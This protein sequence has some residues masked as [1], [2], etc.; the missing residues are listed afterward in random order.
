MDHDKELLPGG[1]LALFSEEEIE[2]LLVSREVAVRKHTGAGLRATDPARYMEV[3]AAL[4]DGSETYRQIAARLHVSRNLIRAVAEQAEN[5]DPLKKR[6]ARRARGLASLCI[7]RL[8][9]IVLDDSSK[10]PARDLAIVAGVAID[11]SQVLTGEPTNITESLRAVPSASQFEGQWD[12]LRQAEGV[13]IEPPAGDQGAGLAG[14]GPQLLGAGGLADPAAG[15]LAG[16]GPQL[17]DADPGAG[18]LAADP[19]AGGLAGH[20][21]Q[22]V[23]AD[24]GAGGL[25]GDPGAGGLAGHGPQLVDADPGAGGLAGDPGA[26]RGPRLLGADPGAGGLADPAGHRTDRAAGC[27]PL[28]RPALGPRT[29]FPD[30]AGHASKT[31]PD[32]PDRALCVGLVLFW[33]CLNVQ[34]APAVRSL[35]SDPGAGG[36]A[37]VR[38][39]ASD[40][41]AGGLAMVR[42]CSVPIRPAA[43]SGSASPARCAYSG[44]APGGGGGSARNAVGPTKWVVPENFISQ[45][46]PSVRPHGSVTRIKAGDWVAAWFK[47]NTDRIRRP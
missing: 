5:V 34:K 16:H 24:P 21:P 17:V 18:G 26:G 46:G 40:P 27:L 37:M 45:R 2:K 28:K 7:E 22:L 23:D 41:G 1:Q 6:I 36:L 42:S 32:V 19:G 33:C 35:A 38:S 30:P 4:A 3:C 29:A 11:K 13:V 39:L 10:I 43:G 9:E 25:A 31:S 44:R 47:S 20:G 8:T 14:H 15:G 12:E